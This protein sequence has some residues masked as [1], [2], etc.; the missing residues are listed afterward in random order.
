MSYFLENEEVE[1]VEEVKEQDGIA[2]IEPLLDNRIVRAIREMGFEKLSPIQEQAIPYLLQGEDII[3]QAQTGTGKTAAFGIP[4]IQHIN[5]DVKKLQTIILC[6]TRELAIQAAEELRKIA[7]YMHGIKVLPVYGGQDISRQIAGLRGV[8]IIVG[9]PGRVMDHMRRRTIK[10]DLV[11]MVVLDEADEMLNMGFREDMELILGQI[12]GEHQT[13]LFSATMPKPILEITDRF[14]KDAKIVKVA[15][16]ELTIPLVSQKFYR[17]KNQDKDAACVRLLEYYQPKLTL[18][19]CNTKKKVD[20]L[21]DLLKEQGFQAEGLH[22]D[23]SQA[24]RDAVMKRFRNGG[25]SILIA[26]DVAARGIDVDDVEAVINYD[27]PQD[28]EYYVHRIGR[29]GR[30][31]RKGRS[32]TFAN[33]RE[34]YKIR[35]IERVC[36][37]TIT[38]KKLPGAAKVL[39]AKADKYLNK[40]WELHEHEDIE[41]MKSFLQRKMEEE[42]CDALELAAAMLKLQVGDKGEEIAADEY[43]KRG[44]RFGDRGRSGRDDGEGRSF[45]RGDGSLAVKTGN[46]E[47]SA[48]V[49]EIAETMAAPVSV[50]TEDAAE[51]KTV[52]M[53]ENGAAVTKR[54]LTAN[55]LGT[56]RREKRKRERNGKSRASV[57]AS[58]RENDL[59]LMRK[60]V[61]LPQKPQLCFCGKSCIVREECIGNNRKVCGMKTL[62]KQ[63]PYILLGATLLLLLGLNIISQDHWLDSDMA[64]EMIFSR[65]LSEEHH[66]FSTTNWYYSTEFRVLYTQLIMGPL[67]RICSNWHVIRTITNL[68]FY[69]LM[70]ASYYYFMK[71]LKVSRGLTVLSSCLLLLPFSET[72]MTHMQ[73]GNTYMSHVILVLWFF[74]MYLRLCSGEYHAKRKVSLWIFYVLLAIVCGMS[75]VRYLLALQCPLVLTSFFYLLGGEE[76]QSFRGEM[77]KEHFQTLFSTDRMR[78]FLYSLA[79][80][81]FAVVGY[82]INVVFISHKYVFQTYGATNFIAL[83]HGV[84]FDRIQNAVGCLLMLFGYI[85]D[86]GF[87]SLR[88]VVTM[89]AFVLLGIYG[90]VTVKSGKMQR[91][92]GFRSL[93][94]LFLK[95]S[96]V[97][98]LFVFIFTTST[99]VPRYYI[100]IFIFALPVLCFYLEEEKMPFDRFAV[101]ALLTICLI[102]GTGKTVMS[103]LTVDK[104]ETKRPVAEFLAGNGY[105]FGFA[106]YNNANIITELTNGE[107][108]IGNIGD[109]EHLEYFKWSSPMKYYEEGYHAGETF[110]LLTAEECAEYAE[111]PALNQGEKVYEDGSYTV[112]VFD[113][114]EDLMDC[115]VAR[116]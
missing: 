61:D 32:F 9:T 55:T 51:M 108:E 80:A 76:F 82:G 104:N 8:Q 57:T 56:E 19:F 95:V 39:K 112:Y 89:A 53:E 77:T 22:G 38:E 36:H 25:T 88:G 102:L 106:T 29:T 1:K 91:V 28:I 69:G 59:N 40:A 98:N 27:I 96:F 58:P 15:A 52:R 3:G 48:A 109:P 107:V 41:L 70:L 17:V 6:P 49:T 85:P 35:E 2:S 114:T 97:L 72:M 24:Q 18:I 33:S 73:M 86:K 62:K 12:P 87:L 79:G 66:I 113:S 23:L 54:R 75:G 5:P 47:D 21:S 68:V 60:L 101:A 63:I 42:G 93:I 103:F 7:K 50:R 43:T 71:P 110:L 116:Q 4:A 16:K 81:F 31:G 74:G 111:A 99:M 92:T 90:Y 34:I 14:Q 30:A 64:A 67:F 94:T 11:N 46:A 115:A 37:T 44:N 45:G 100:T 26:T 13:A 105:D 65:I 20:E 83:Y 78:Y 10:L 84:L